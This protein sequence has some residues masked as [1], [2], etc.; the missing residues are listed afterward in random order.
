VLVIHPFDVSIQKQ[1]QIR[2]KLFEN[3]DIL[4]DF[5]LITIPAVQSIAGNKT[6]F[7]NW[8]D[9]L[10]HMHKEIDKVDFDVAI[11][12]AGSYGLPLSAYIKAK[13]KIAIHMGGATQVLF[14]IK[15]K[16]WD[17]HPVI[18]RFYNEFWVRPEISELV[19]NADKVEGGCY[20]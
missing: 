11:I 18:S 20:W 5:Q 14:G 1:Y 13:G 9:A 10:E 6:E 19:P 17:N 16:R 3:P 4:P 15:G 2:T 8:F 7:D 12:G